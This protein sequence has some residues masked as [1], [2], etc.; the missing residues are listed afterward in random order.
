MSNPTAEEQ[1]A[2]PVETPSQKLARQ[3]VNRR[4]A[5]NQNDQQLY[6]EIRSAIRQTEAAA[7]RQ[8]RER[9]LP[10]LVRVYLEHPMAISALCDKHIDRSGA[11]LGEV[12]D[13]AIRAREGGGENG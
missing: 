12:R 13:G 7:V 10:G 5:L 6:H 1:V 2:T 4:N 8:E 3:I 11:L 9:I